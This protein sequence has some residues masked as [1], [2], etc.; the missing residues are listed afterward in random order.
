MAKNPI[1]GMGVAELAA[2]RAMMNPA[3]RQVYGSFDAYGKRRFFGPSQNEWGIA[4]GF[5]FELESVSI[6]GNAPVAFSKTRAYVCIDEDE[7]GPVVEVWPIRN[8][9]HPGVPNMSLSGWKRQENPAPASKRVRVIGSNPTRADDIPGDFSQS[10]AKVYGRAW[11]DAESATVK[12]VGSDAVV[13][14]TWSDGEWL[15]MVYDSRAGALKNL[16]KLG[17]A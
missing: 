1:K 3:L 4:Q 13:R 7:R 9:A 16:K 17:F 11:S 12:D 8:L 6:Y 15:Q 2:K 5:P 10:S 14:L